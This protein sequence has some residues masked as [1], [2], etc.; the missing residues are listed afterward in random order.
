MSKHK[1]SENEYLFKVN[2]KGRRSI[3]RTVLLRGDQ[4]LDDLH[5][6]IFAA[7]DRYDEHLYC[8]YF[9]KGR[10]GRLASGKPPKEY[11]SPRGFDRT[12]E[13]EIDNRYNAAKARLDD[14]RLK[15]GQTFEYLFDFGDEWWHEII[16]QGIG[17][18]ES[19]ETYPRILEK[20]L[21]SPPQYPESDE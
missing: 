3:W 20:R 21:A 12:D 6:A 15:V 19:G 4:T 14:L 5:E 7:F 9:P 10:Q 18:S 11:R 8:F 17:P 1:E 16:V 2:L 13:F